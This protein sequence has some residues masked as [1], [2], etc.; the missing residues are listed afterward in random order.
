MGQPPGTARA[1]SPHRLPAWHCPLH[2]RPTS[3]PLSSGG[4]HREH[5]KEAPRLNSVFSRAYLWQNYRALALPSPL[6]DDS[7]VP[8]KFWA[9]RRTCG[10]DLIHDQYSVAGGG[11]GTPAG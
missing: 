1:L 4:R 11:H 6:N 8:H 10:T 3:T 7:G 9:W 2:H 5:R